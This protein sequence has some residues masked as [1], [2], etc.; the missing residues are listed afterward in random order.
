VAA[1]GVG[2]ELLSSSLAALLLIL[3]AVWY[4]GLGVREQPE[5]L[6]KLR[7]AGLAMLA[8]L[9]S[10]LYALLVAALGLPER[11]AALLFTLFLATAAASVTVTLAAALD[12]ALLTRLRWA[13]VL[14]IGFVTVVAVS[15]TAAVASADSPTASQGVLAGV[16]PSVSVYP[17]GFA[18]GLLALVAPMEWVVALDRRQR[19]GVLAGWG[20]A[21]VPLAVALGVGRL[22]P[23]PHQ[24][25]LQDATH[26]GAL[27]C[28]VFVV[29]MLARATL[30]LPGA[31]AYER[32]VRELD[33]IYDFGL[34]AGTAFSPTELQS[35]ALESVLKVVEP[36]VALLIEPNP[37]GPGCVCLLSRADASGR[38][39]YRFRARTPWGAIAERF[40]DRAPVVVV[41]H[42]K[43]PPGVL[44]RIWEPASGSSVIVPA[45]GQSG[46]PSAVLI[47]GRFQR[48]AFNTAEVRSLAGFANQVALAMD[49][50]R[51][52]RETVESERRQRELEIAREL[53]VNLLP[54]APPSIAGLDIADRSEPATEVGGDYFDY[55][56]LGEGRLG[57]VVGDVA[58]HGMPAGLMMAMAKSAIHTQVQVGGTPSVL[59][60][61]LSETLLG[62]S[63]DN[64]FMTMV[65][66]ELD[67]D[68]GE[69][70][71]SN[72]GHHYPLHLQA[73]TGE[74]VEL[75]STGVPLG[76]LAIPPG[77]FRSCPMGPG[78]IFLF[79]SDGL[80]EATGPNSEEMFG[81][82]RLKRVLLAN[83]G[84]SAKTILEACFHAVRRFAGEEPLHD[85]AT[86]VVVKL[87][88]GEGS[89]CGGEGG[90]ASL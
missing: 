45:I 30:A 12:L 6:P 48:Y 73:A 52:L 42:R 60:E 68:S 55:L 14:A 82:S 23:L 71:Y 34:T 35:A 38:H 86:M 5:A 66:A 63:A 49:H 15:L 4:W 36:D 74:I 57:V 3:S 53:Q 70:R 58:G 19:I 78:D 84:R 32:K 26:A 67:I 33:A 11:L 40:A 25:L 17:L 29:V 28:L 20:T 64:Q 65:F 51:L 90:D 88:P 47:V 77:P 16:R 44:R 22:V 54:K 2:G 81:T 61:R 80:V 1:F 62:L 75:E 76:L 9:M 31:R 8:L 7:V 41:D 56:D 72:A 46:A 59:I 69:F 89:S 43:A 50:A 79:Y 21:V 87:E 18:V 85:D 27:F 39:A 83:R 24:H 13:R 37:E 10:L